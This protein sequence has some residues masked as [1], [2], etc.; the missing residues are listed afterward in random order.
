MAYLI[1]ALCFGIAG[2]IVGRMKGS[3]FWIWFLISAI[4]PIAGLVAAILYRSEKEEP[5][6]LCPRCGKLLKLYVQVCPRCGTDSSS[7]TRPTPKA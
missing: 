2:G 1:I 4:V 7:A 5:E 6:R 3:S